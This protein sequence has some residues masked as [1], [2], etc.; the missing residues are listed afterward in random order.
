MNTEERQYKKKLIL[1][2]TMSEPLETTGLSC[3]M[4]TNHVCW[5]IPFINPLLLTPVF[6]CMSLQLFQTGKS[7]QLLNSTELKPKVIACSY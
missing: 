5:M 1:S 6:I 4:T 2:K 3:I 7:Q